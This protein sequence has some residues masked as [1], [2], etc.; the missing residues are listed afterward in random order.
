MLGL[1]IPTHEKNI[2]RYMMS[3][4]LQRQVSDVAQDS[5]TKM[6]FLSK[7]RSSVFYFSEQSFLSALWRR[8]KSSSGVPN[9]KHLDRIEN[10]TE[11]THRKCCGALDRQAKSEQTFT[12]ATSPTAG[13]TVTST[14]ATA[15]ATVPWPRLRVAAPTHPLTPRRPHPQT[16]SSDASQQHV[17]PQK[18]TSFEGHPLASYAVVAPLIHLPTASSA[19]NI[20]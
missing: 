3:Q 11:N 19:A 9:K 7:L 1:R 8:K 18:A 6:K 12:C 14:E 4:R 16:T 15:S 10:R 2:P 5:I 13:C 20:P 17:C